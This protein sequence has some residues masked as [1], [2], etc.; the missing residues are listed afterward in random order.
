MC[1]PAH[2]QCSPKPSYFRV[3]LLGKERFQVFVVKIIISTHTQCQNRCDF[4]CFR[5]RYYPLIRMSSLHYQPRCWIS[6]QANLA[7][8]SAEITACI[9]NEVS[10]NQIKVLNNVHGEIPFG[11]LELF[12]YVE[13]FIKKLALHFKFN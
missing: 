9:V 7:Y 13:Q 3:R 5:R 8:W 11:I 2:K 12:V 4:L 6:N 10:L 1:L